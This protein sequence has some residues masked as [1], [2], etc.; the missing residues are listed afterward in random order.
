MKLN[1]KHNPIELKAYAQFLSK[2]VTRKQD[3]RMAWQPSLVFAKGH[4]HGLRSEYMGMVL[5]TDFSVDMPV[6][7]PYDTYTS[8]S[9]LNDGEFDLESRRNG[10]YHI[11]KLNHPAYSGS[12]PTS[13]MS[14]LTKLLMSKENDKLNRFFNVKS[15]VIKQSFATIENGMFFRNFLIQQGKDYLNPVDMM[16]IQTDKVVLSGDTGQFKIS[17]YRSTI[18]PSAPAGARNDV[19]QLNKDHSF[20]KSVIDAITPFDNLYQLPI[21]HFKHLVS[22][23][24]SI[25][26]TYTLAIIQDSTLAILAESNSKGLEYIYYTTPI[27]ANIE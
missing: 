3:S 27:K 8:L 19:M 7:I 10:D 18:D 11:I 16:D 5:T 26:F 13:S 17:A 21:D 20:E 2:F 1:V 9:S 15:M 23:E 22:M 6:A 4:Q 25:P 14:T 12:I 24:N